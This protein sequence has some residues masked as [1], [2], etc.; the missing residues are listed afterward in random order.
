MS[1]QFLRKIDAL[2]ITTKQLV[3]IIKQLSDEMVLM[4][5]RVKALEARKP[6]GRPPK[7][8]RKETT[9]SD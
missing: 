4:E 2:E 6:V 8:G 3:D 1:A 7:D 9:G 5:D